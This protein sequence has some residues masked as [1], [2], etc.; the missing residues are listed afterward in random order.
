[1]LAYMIVVLLVHTTHA[2]TFQRTVDDGTFTIS[3][4]EHNSSSRSKS[5]SVV[6]E[7][8]IVVVSSSENKVSERLSN[9]AWSGNT[10]LSTEVRHVIGRGSKQQLDRSVSLLLSE[11]VEC[12]SF[13]LSSTEQP[14]GSETPL[15][16]AAS[17]FVFRFCAAAAA[18]SRFAFCA[19]RRLR[20]LRLLS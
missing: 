7:E 9:S 6:F 20:L 14:Y 17:K 13:K 18:A 5:V 11:D 1:M 15:V 19:A 3:C 4:A 2:S 8:H 12:S 10:M 16:V